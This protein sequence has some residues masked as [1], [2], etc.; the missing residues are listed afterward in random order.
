MATYKNGSQ[1]SSQIAEALRSHDGVE[2]LWWR[3]NL[4]TGPSFIRELKLGTPR[5]QPLADDLVVLTST[6]ATVTH[7][8]GHWMSYRAV[9]RAELAKA[10]PRCEACK[11]TGIKTLSHF[12]SR[13]DFVCSCTGGKSYERAHLGTLR[14]VR[15][16]RFE[17]V[18]VE[19]TYEHQHDGEV[20]ARFDNAEAAA[21][22]A[23]EI[24]THPRFQP[25]FWVGGPTYRVGVRVKEIPL[26]EWA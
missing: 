25:G 5:S 2:V 16:D 21:T 1:V 7:G 6:G 22:R 20:L 3:H 12:E 14:E 19:K 24:A 11:G 26:P 13:I 4:A 15:L 23:A 10:H 17:V 9:S 8:H 18:A